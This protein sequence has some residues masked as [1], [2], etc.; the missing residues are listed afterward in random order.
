MTT[1]RRTFLQYA[2][3]GYVGL[4]AGPLRS[5]SAAAMGLPAGIQLYTVRDALR[6]DSKATLQAL[7]QMGYREAEPAGYG[8]HSASEFNLLLRDIGLKCPSVH[9]ALGGDDLGPVFDD[10]HTMGAH[11]AV[12]GSLPLEHP[13]TSSTAAVDK[14]QPTQSAYRELYKR[15]AEK[16]NDIGGKAKAAGLQYA[17]HNH[18]REFV[19]AGEGLSGYDVLLSETDPALVSFEIDCGWMVM[20]GADPVQYM[21]KHPSRF[22]MLHIKDFKAR[23]KAGSPTEGAELGTGFID[24]GP[25]FSAGR[26]IGIQH[27]FAEQEPPYTHSQLD[28]A[29]VDC[30]YLKA[31]A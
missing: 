28:S 16:L 29:K 7:H 4:F 15:L 20:G 18:N 14:Q 30:A 21:E 1:T 5:A 27:A 26:R 22:R 19:E 31:H 6:S 10:V 11:Y 8:G 9:V 24:Y 25:I 17:Y 23:P 13:S 3:G 2:I 12:S